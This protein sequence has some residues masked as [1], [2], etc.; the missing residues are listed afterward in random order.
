MV[1]SITAK[2][3]NPSPAARWTLSFANGYLDLGMLEKA[4]R[5]LA[6]LPATD[7]HQPEALVLAGRILIARRK[8]EEALKLFAIGRVLYPHTSDF[9]IQ[10]AYAYEKMERVLESKSMWELVPQPIRRSGLAHFNLARCEAKLGNLGAAKR[11]LAQAVILDPN[12]KEV[13]T[14]EPN[15]DQLLQLDN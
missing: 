2:L 7:H 13:L 10:A 15:L 6:N 11:H 1:A 8:W 14:Q 12:F 9:Y 5:E 4:E 3:P